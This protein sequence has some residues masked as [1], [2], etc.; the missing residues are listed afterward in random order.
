MSKAFHIG[1]ILS[2]TT[3]RLVSPRHM[4]GVYEIL[5]YMTG[6]NLFTH[7]LPR[8]SNECKPHLLRQHPKLADADVSPL[9]KLADDTAPDARRSLI[10]GWMRMQVAAFGETLLVEPIPQDDHERKNPWDELVEMRGSDEGVIPVVI[11]DDSA[12]SR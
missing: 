10:D 7:Q 5:N 11:D 2:I 6:D 8:A 9:D 4:E 1:D 3:G 12:V